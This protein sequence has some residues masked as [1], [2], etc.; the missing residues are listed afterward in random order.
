MKICPTESKCN[1]LMHNSHTL[2]KF[3]N[4]FG[5]YILKLIEIRLNVLNC[6]LGMIMIYLI[7]NLSS[8]TMTIFLEQQFRFV[9]YTFIEFKTI[10]RTCPIKNMEDPL[11]IVLI[12]NSYDYVL[13]K[14]IP[15]IVILHESL[16][17]MHYTYFALYTLGTA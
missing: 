3:L 14:W 7:G 12:P 13:L 16:P 5:L 17:A 10:F 4:F 15:H 11:W 2:F 9:S 6:F 1:E 8:T